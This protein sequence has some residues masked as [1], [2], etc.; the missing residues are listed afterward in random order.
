MSGTWLRRSSLP[1]ALYTLLTI[2]FPVA[3][4]AYFVAPNVRLS[5]VRLPL[6]WLA[7]QRCCPAPAACMA[8]WS[9]RASA[10]RACPAPAPHATMCSWATQI[11]NGMPA[12]GLHAL[13]SPQST[14]YHT[15][16]YV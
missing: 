1:G 16:G 8:R 9:E 12:H 7:P 4:L 15:F 2:A 11:V 5:P 6:K 14:L 10:P 3:G 13:P